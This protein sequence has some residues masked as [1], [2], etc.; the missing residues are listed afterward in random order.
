MKATGVAPMVFVTDADPVMDSA[1]KQVYKNTYSLHCI[2]H[3]NQ[4]LPKNLKEILDNAYDQFVKDF[5]LCHN[6]LDEMLFE[7]R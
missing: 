7:S 1:V 2:F 5:Y 3:I 6:T 4:N